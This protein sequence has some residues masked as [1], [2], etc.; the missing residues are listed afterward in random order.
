MWRL[1]ACG[2]HGQHFGIAAI[3]AIFHPSVERIQQRADGRNH[4]AAIFE[5][6]TRQGKRMQ[7]G[8]EVSKVRRLVGKCAGVCKQGAP[9]QAIVASRQTAERPHTVFDQISRRVGFPAETPG[10]CEYGSLARLRADENCVAS[11]RCVIQREG[12]NKQAALVQAA[13]A[14][15]RETC[16]EQPVAGFFR[17]ASQC[18]FRHGT[19]PRLFHAKQRQRLAKPPGFLLTGVLVRG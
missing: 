5:H 7:T 2:H 1:L 19:R 18:R 11:Q 13:F 12:V 6:L 9:D 16:V 10:L 15:E 14:P 17:P 8:G 4:A 3:G